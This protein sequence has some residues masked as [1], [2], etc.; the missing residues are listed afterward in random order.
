[1][2]TRLN[3]KD[4]EMLSAY[5]DGQVSSSEKSQIDQRL[6]SD[7]EWAA[8]YRSLVKTRAILREIPRVKR[9][10]NYFL[11]PEMVRKIGWLRIIPT[12]NFSSAA[13]AIFAVLL[14]ILDVFP[15]GTGDESSNCSPGGCSGGTRFCCPVCCGSKRPRYIGIHY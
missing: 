3:D 11:T 8:A 7:P 4:W 15:N 12:L 9:R 1:M 14:F 5:M 10:R 13:A 2:T 6:K